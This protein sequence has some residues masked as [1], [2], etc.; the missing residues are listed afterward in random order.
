MD[1]LADF[2]ITQLPVQEKKLQ[3]AR[4]HSDEIRLLMPAKTSSG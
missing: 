1:N 4:I 3:V 2:G